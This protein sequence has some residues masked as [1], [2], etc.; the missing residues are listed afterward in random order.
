MLYIFSFLF[1]YIIINAQENVT[2]I[3]G[4]QGGYFVSTNMSPV[5]TNDSNILL[6]FESDGITYSTGVDDAVLTSNGIMYTATNFRAFPVPADIDYD[7]TELL[8]IGNNW[9]GVNQTNSSSDYIYGFSPIIPT[10]S[11]RDGENGLEMASNFFNIQSQDIEY[12]DLTVLSVPN[13]TDNTPDIIVTQTGDPSGSD[14]FK[15]VD[16][17]GK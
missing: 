10:N 9:G 6:G 8:G 3:Y 11:L 2:T 7:V 15:F 5:N 12:D 14:T 1:S 17:L 13:I 4:N 16:N